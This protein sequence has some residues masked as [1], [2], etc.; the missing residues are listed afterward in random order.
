[1]CYFCGYSAKCEDGHLRIVKKVR[2]KNII[3]SFFFVQIFVS[4]FI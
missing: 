4:N 3:Y 2:D 1:M